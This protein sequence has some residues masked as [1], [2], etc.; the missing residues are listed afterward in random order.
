M[1]STERVWIEVEPFSILVLPG[2]GAAIGRFAWRHPDGDWRELM[3]RPTD[4]QID[5]ASA[6]LSLLS[7]FV[8]APFANRIDEAQF[9][10]DGVAHRLPLNRPEQNCAIHGL[11]RTEDWRV[12][13]RAPGRVVCE[14]DFAD[15]SAPFRYRA[16]QSIAIDDGMVVWDLSVEN[17]GAAA[18]PFGFGLHPWFPRSD[19]S[20][21]R[22]AAAATFASDERTFPTAVAPV[23]GEIDFSSGRQI[24]ASPGMDRHYAGWDGV[25]RIE[26]PDF[27]YAIDLTAPAAAAGQYR[28]LH[29]FCPTDRPSFCVEPVTHVTDVV[30]RREFAPHGDMTRLEPGERL[31]ARLKVTATPL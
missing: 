21:I 28:N 16:R 29:V 31:S 15:E 26:Q 27:G 14:H 8:M 1:T 5:D 9:S 23:A 12:S 6:S 30:N 17:Q 24:A 3:D 20:V 25:A 7:S 10:Y 13:E 11:S 4:A 18:M 19:R 22:F 2:R